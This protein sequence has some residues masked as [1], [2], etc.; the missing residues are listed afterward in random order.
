VTKI[1][2]S[3]FGLIIFFVACWIYAMPYLAVRGMKKA[4]ED[5]DAVALAD[6]VNFPALK[7]SL[8]ASFTAQMVKSTGEELKDNP[9]AAL[10]VAMAN[11]LAI[12]M[13]DSLV[14]PEGLAAMMSGHKPSPSYPNEEKPSEMR[15]GASDD[16]PIVKMGYENFN[17]FTVSTSD[18]S[19]PTMVVTMVYLRD[20]L[21]WKLSAIRLPSDEPATNHVADSE[22]LTIESSSMDADSVRPN[23][24]TLTAVLHNKTPY[25][26]AFPDLEL[27]LNDE[28]DK[29]IAR[30]IFHSPEYFP[31]VGNTKYILSPDQKIT[32]AFTINA[33]ELSPSGYRLE[34]L[35]PKPRNTVAQTSFPTI[36]LV[37]PNPAGGGG[38]QPNSTQEQTT[39]N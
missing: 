8:K 3:I 30:R 17:R 33:V 18:K 11:V 36:Q 35:P 7:E 22:L 5:R 25:A 39:T 21:S 12:P 16:E 31:A 26:Q 15:S 10:G 2:K 28:G 1:K 27:T 4:V 6:Y 20:G 19:H 37:T 23:I 24:I 32:V 38:N 34:S 29:P 14:S 9:F 13:I